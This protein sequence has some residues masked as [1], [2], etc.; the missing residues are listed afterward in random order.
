MKAARIC[1]G[2]ADTGKLTMLAKPENLMVSTHKPLHATPAIK[3]KN[4]RTLGFSVCVT[5]H[6][7][8]FNSGKVRFGRH[9][10]GEHPLSFSTASLQC[11]VFFF[12][13]E[14]MTILILSSSHFKFRVNDSNIRGTCYQ[15]MITNTTAIK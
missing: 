12:F 6:A 1:G 8:W 7:V 2:V 11:L 3:K 13:L 4:M 10:I 15:L 9:C 5:P 14:P